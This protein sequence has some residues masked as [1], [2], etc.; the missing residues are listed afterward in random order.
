MKRLGFAS[1]SA[2]FCLASATSVF[3]Q[4]QPSASEKCNEK[5]RLSMAKPEDMKLFD[6][7]INDS[8]CKDSMYRETVFN[9]T[10]QKY[11]A[12]MKWKEV[13]DLAN[14]YEKEVNPKTDQLKK[15]FAQ[16]GLT[17]ASQLGDLN[18]ILDMGEKVLVI[19]PT[20]LNALVI[21]IGALPEKYPTLTDQAAKD[22]NL[23]R[24]EELA[25][26]I[27]GMK[28]PDG[29]TDPVWQQ[30]VI[31][32]AH[33]VLGFVAL[34]RQQYPDA[35][36]EYE[37][38]VKINPKDQVSWF[39]GGLARIFI[40]T[41]AQ[42]PLKDLYDNANAITTPGPERDAA[43][44]KRDAGVKE[45]TDKRD[46]AMDW[47]ATATAMGGPVG[48]AAKKQLELLWKPAH[49]DTTEGMDDFIAKHKDY[50]IPSQ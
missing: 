29:L 41:A 32:P 30:S 13:Y 12:A 6:D 38:A 22:K 50:K 43:D 16:Y 14:R 17:A 4:A 27:L 9:T 23:A 19:D 20:D 28:M 36:G 37:K 39:R 18:M 1:L 33:A 11:I 44:Q 49:N 48:D 25:K 3:A 7:F 47:L 5:V 34:Q 42:K 46:L 40:A 45:Y 24:S 2:L 15:F 26:K 10:F 8:T 31:G 35:S 21:L